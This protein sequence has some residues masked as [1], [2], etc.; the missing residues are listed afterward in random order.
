MNQKLMAVASRK[1]SEYEILLEKMERKKKLE[2]TNWVS[3]IN[4]RASNHRQQ[5]EERV[6]KEILLEMAW[7]MKRAA[8]IA[9][10]TDGI[11][12]ICEQEEIDANL[13][14]LNIPLC[15]FCKKEHMIKNIDTREVC[16]K[17][18]NQLFPEKISSVM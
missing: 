8:E 1:V 4:E 6:Q 7:D 10:K 15:R 16:R 13:L 18:Y 5:E 9:I 2:A 3:D 11:C 17:K 14:D 12:P